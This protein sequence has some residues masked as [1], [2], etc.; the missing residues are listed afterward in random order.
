MRFRVWSGK[1]IFWR[2]LEK[3]FGIGFRK[4]WIF[5]NWYFVQTRNF[6]FFIVWIYICLYVCKKSFRTRWWLNAF[7]KIKL[8]KP[9][10]LIK[11]ALILFL[12]KA[13]CKSYLQFCYSIIQWNL[14]KRLRF[15]YSYNYSS[16]EY[17]FFS[18]DINHDAG[19]NR[20]WSWNWF[21]AMSLRE[22]RSSTILD[23]FCLKQET[24]VRA[25]RS[26]KRGR[27]WGRDGEGRDF[28]TKQF[29]RY[30]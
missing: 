2:F 4:H 13:R 28:S 7:E 25:V 26:R 27:R 10:E 3:S 18:N 11:L 12:N 17:Y 19:A 16:Q 23:V 30:N 15:N 22:I 8:R 29:E 20:V 14:K 21:L 9:K 5:G 24:F 1:R 6:S